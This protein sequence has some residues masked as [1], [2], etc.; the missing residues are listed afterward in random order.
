MGDI[1]QGW[2]GRGE[3]K[4]HVLSPPGIRAHKKHQCVHQPGYSLNYLIQHV[5]PWPNYTGAY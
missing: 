5:L 2:L 4:G 1:G 3:M